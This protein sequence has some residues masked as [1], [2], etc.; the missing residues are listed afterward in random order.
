MRFP[1][2]FSGFALAGLLIA[3][4]VC[5]FSLT[6]SESPAPA[7]ASAQSPA[8]AD[9]EAVLR[10]TS[11]LVLLDVIVTEKDKAVQGIDRSRFHLFEDGKEQAIR[12]FDEHRLP[13]GA[14]HGSTPPPSRASLPP[15]T[16]TNIPEFPDS[17]AVTVLLLDALNTS[18]EGQLNVRRQM[19]DYMRKIKPGT[20]LAIFTL[21][22]RLRMLTNFSTDMT[23]LAKL[24]NSPKA[25][26]QQPVM[27]GTT[28][29]AQQT[30]VTTGL[31]AASSPVNSP[32]NDALAAGAISGTV[33]GP[34]DA[35]A[36]MQQ[37]QADTL[38]YQSDQR[39]RITLEAFRQLAQYLSA[40]PGR[41]NV[42]W[43][44][45]AFPFVIDPD[46]SLYDKFGAARTYMGDVRQTTEILSDARM[47]IYPIDAR[48]LMAPGQYN[49]SNAGAAANNAS[50]QERKEVVLEQDS[51]QQ[52]AKDTGG[53]AYFDKN[54][55]G[56]AVADIVESGSSYYT[57][58]FV[59]AK[60]ELD[61][62]FH[63]FKVHLDGAS[64]K[65]AYRS[66]YFADPPDKPSPHRPDE[67]NMIALATVHG[68]PPATQILF[69][70]RVLPASDPLLKQ[71]KLTQGPVGDSA[72]ALKGTPH[73]YVVDLVV[74]LHGIVFDMAADG[75]HQAYVE[76]ALVAFDADG[77]RI[78][79]LEHGFQLAIRPDRFAQL[80]A[81]GIPVRMEIDLPEGQNSLRIGIH[82]VAARRTGSLEVPVTVLPN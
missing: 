52:V 49:A 37:F 70:A 2:S 44:S 76:F 26:V 80:M 6:A 23:A 16:Y 51:M 30:E 67:T 74:D 56:D 39:V 46:P 71:A 73:R 68:A 50:M 1:G 45:S 82:D 47:A 11:N 10:T 60:N 5:S 75:T 63:R 33:G 22:S 62:E 81:S 54:D 64:F 38:S 18:I 8:P 28:T 31:L 69:D 20:P 79:Y 57:L 77:N 41:K 43:F 48:G 58:G 78:N 3:S 24:M 34:I 29:L 66:G 9:S 4:P 59:P 35:A 32:Q 14:S 40:I 25:T 53:K 15:H 72:A 21:S 13:D 61:G 27:A 65:L 7:P 36:A 12:S 55:F 42:I 19:I 17:S